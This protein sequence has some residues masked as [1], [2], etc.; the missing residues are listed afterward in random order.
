MMNEEISILLLFIKKIVCVCVCER[1]IWSRWWGVA[2]SLCVIWNDWFWTT[3]FCF[4]SCKDSQKQALKMKDNLGDLGWKSWIRVW[5]PR[6]EDTHLQHF[7]L[8]W[9]ELKRPILFLNSCVCLEFWTLSQVENV[10]H[11]LEL[12]R[13]THLPNSYAQSEFWTFS[14]VKRMSMNFFEF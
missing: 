12:K 5:L 7:L 10:G 14:W 1:E 8:T 11:F 4:S 13:P 9:L 3:C 6:L 2:Q